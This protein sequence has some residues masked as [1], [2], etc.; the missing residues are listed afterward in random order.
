MRRFPNTLNELFHRSFARWA[1][2]C[3]QES[4]RGVGTLGLLLTRR[5]LHR[6]WRREQQHIPC[7]F[8]LETGRFEPVGYFGI[9]TL[10]HDIIYCP[11]LRNSMFS[12]EFKSFLLPGMVHPDLY[13]LLP[14]PRQ[15]DAT[16]TRRWPCLSPC[17]PR[18]DSSSSITSVAIACLPSGSRQEGR[19]TRAIAESTL[20]VPSHIR[21]GRHIAVATPLLPAPVDICLVQLRAEPD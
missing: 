11:A 9:Q 21:M 2:S 18:H 12:I 20:L 17:Q 8:S 6:S 1:R 15:L 14:V 7:A 10:I 19:T 5:L 13:S 16:T 3:Q 4:E